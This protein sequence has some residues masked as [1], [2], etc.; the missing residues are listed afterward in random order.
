MNSKKRLVLITIILLLIAEFSLPLAVL[1]AQSPAGTITLTVGVTDFMRD[2]FND[3]LIHD[4]EASHPGIKL[5]VVSNSQQIPFASSG[6]D[7]YFEALQK[8][9]SAADVLYVDLNHL[10]SPLATQAGY[11]LDLAPLIAVDSSFNAD[12]FL[13]PVWQN[14]RWDNGTWALP[15]SASAWVLV[16]DPA[17][18]DKAGLAYPNARWTMDDLA[19][20][21][22]ALGQK[23]ADGHVTSPGLA[24]DQ[25]GPILLFMSL[26]GDTLVDSSTVP[27]PPQLEKP[28]LATMLDT[29]AKLNQEGW[30]GSDFL[31][32]PLSIVPAGV[33]MSVNN[34]DRKLV[35]TLLPGGKAGL[36]VQ[37]FAVSSGTQYPEQ[38][39]ELA[40]FLATRTELGF[41]FL[42]TSARK[43]ATPPSGANAS[44][45]IQ[46]P[47]EVQKL[48]DEALAN[49]LPLADLRYADYLL[50][51]L[52]AMK[53]NGLD[54]QAALQQVQI[55]A[56]K[57]QQAALAQKDKAALV[58]ATPIPQP[59]PNAGKITLN[60]GLTSFIRPIP[61]RDLWDRV[62]ADFAASD[63]Q[64]GKVNLNIRQG[65]GQDQDDCYYLPYN[66]VPDGDLSKLLNLDPF[67][68]ADSAFDKGD[69]LGNLLSQVT[70]ENKIW[71]MPLTIEPAVLLYNTELFSK[72]N[73]PQPDAGW[74]MDAFLDALHALKADPNGS[75]P[76]VPRG[77]GGTGQYML[78][79]IAAN[80]GLPLDY[81]TSPPTVSFTD[82]ATVQA[83]RQILDLARQGYMKY[84]KLATSPFKPIMLIAMGESTNDPIYTEV[85]NAF[86]LGRPNRPTNSDTSPYKMTT[87]P[88][89]TKYS[90][91]TYTMSTAYISAGAQNPEACYRL[92]KTLATHP[93]LFGSMPARRSS[94][95][96]P[97]LKAAQGA[98]LSALYDQIDALLKDPNTIAFPSGFAGVGAARQ[99]LEYWLFSA[100]D[101]YVLENGDLDVALQDAQTF[102][103]AF[104]GCVAD[105]PAPAEGSQPVDAFQKCAE[106]IDPS[107]KG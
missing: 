55:Q 64:V 36:D 30:I 78:M 41:R 31:K 48:N 70:R 35:G 89:G 88:R 32:A 19:A 106:Q 14:Y 50:L 65:N 61:N 52:D 56:I 67:L 26:L 74:T 45:V 72:A 33:L 40:K 85:L 53:K 97:A 84:S 82:P 2:I 69:M 73:V 100:F 95:S 80:G 27:N 18:F 29:W 24:A 43:S 20:A 59:T 86:A 39:Y 47:P 58:V 15:V 51:A 68:N 7:K 11:F 5:N 101:K 75:A 81:R 37:G 38:A 54:G 77:I 46:I 93:E 13:A 105:V 83:I 17:A 12:D 23:D 1:R 60:F 16:Y 4:F 99:M 10:N 103:Q 96:S 25:E 57:A 63:P 98:D 79:L 90:A 6:T 9:A 71:G 8:F 21:V 62:L 49:G 104:L 3:Q 34:Q 102:A 66:A 22:R 28:A 44:P 91:L 87:H 76:F 107:L 94:L 92:L 42:G